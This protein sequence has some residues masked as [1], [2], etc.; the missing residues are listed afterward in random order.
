MDIRILISDWY[1]IL[2]HIFFIMNSK[3][4]LLL[5]LENS[6]R[7]EFSLI[8][9]KLFFLIFGYSFIVFWL[10][11]FN[12]QK[13]NNWRI[14]HVVNTFHEHSC[15][16]SGLKKNFSTKNNFFFVRIFEEHIKLTKYTW[17]KWFLNFLSYNFELSKGLILKM[18]PKSLLRSK[19]QRQNLL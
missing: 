19:K 17:L 15:V 7:C 9:F 12:I 3:R 1:L 4:L 14:W 11:L 10:F 13:K 2:L 8:L 5:L 18:R 6:S 16:Y